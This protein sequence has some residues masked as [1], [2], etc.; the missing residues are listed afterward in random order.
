MPS[1]QQCQSTEGTFN[2]QYKINKI[3]S[4]VIRQVTVFNHIWSRNHVFKDSQIYSQQ[5]LEPDIRYIP[6]FNKLSFQELLG[7]E[8]GK[9]LGITKAAFTRMD[10]LPFA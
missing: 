9:L 3:S 10:A 5:E 6:I 8:L 2:S 7:V 4:L 1:N